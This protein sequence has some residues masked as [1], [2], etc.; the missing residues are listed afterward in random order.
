MPLELKELMLASGQYPGLS[1]RFAKSL[2]LSTGMLV[3]DVKAG[4][5]TKEQLEEFVRWEVTE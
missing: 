1:G 4:K 3:L 5:I 2:G